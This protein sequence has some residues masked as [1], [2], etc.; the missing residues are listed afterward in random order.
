MSRT[1][2]WCYVRSYVPEYGYDIYKA[3]PIETV[4]GYF[5]DAY[6]VLVEK[7]RTTPAWS[8]NCGLY[9]T[10]VA[11]RVVSSSQCAVF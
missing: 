7:V 2:S 1:D 9:C 5:K 8:V 4:C 6:Y 3:D 11:T 10:L